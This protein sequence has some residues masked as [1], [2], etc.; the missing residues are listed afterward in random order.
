MRL[1]PGARHFQVCE[2]PA[3]DLAGTGEHLYV[4]V[5]KEDLNTDD[6][7]DALAA[8]AGQRARDVGFAGRKDRVAIARQWFSVRLADESRLSALASPHVSGRLELRTVSRH[9]SKLRL[10]DLRGNRFRLGIGG[11]DEPAALARLE[12]A[13]AELAEA[14]IENRFGPQRFGTGLSN[15]AIARAW[16][17]GDFARAAELCVDPSG[18]WTLADPLPGGF[19]TGPTGN[20]LGALRRDASDPRAALSRAGPRFA[21]LVASAAQSAIFNAVLD[22]RRARGMLRRLRAGDAART[23]E[24]GLIRCFAEDLETHNARAAP[25]RLEVFATGPLPGARV[26]RPS[27]EIESEERADSASLG[28]D[29]AW[30]DEG[31]PLESPGE[32]RNLIVPLLEKPA[33][34]REGEC[35]WLTFALPPGAYAT[36][37]LT[38]L[39]VEVPERRG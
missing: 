38:Q 5:E 20:V 39:G 13:L 8:V 11:A 36:E 23:R 26:F 27:R 15:L 29:W 21:K 32:R 10:G 12:R 1:L 16:G 35:T 9:T 3:Y 7:A 33:L 18:A 17:S 31:G 24:G 4:E 2:L 30:L 28:L 37:L 19:R 25:G 6:V 14:G 34:E 22:A